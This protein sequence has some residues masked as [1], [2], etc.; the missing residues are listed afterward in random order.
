MVAIVLGAGSGE[1]VA[2]GEPKA[3]LEIGGRPLLAWAAEAMATAPEVGSLVVTA[4]DGAR[5]RAQACLEG[6]PVPVRVVTGGATRQASVKAAL[7]AVPA[8]AEVVVIHDAARPFA[9]PALCSRVVV[10]VRSGADGAVPVVAVSDTVK[11]VRDGR[12]ERTIDRATLALAQT[13]QAFRAELLRTAHERAA[14]SGVSV[15]DDAALLEEAADVRAVDGEAHNVK[16]T[17]P[18]D[19]DRARTMAAEVRGD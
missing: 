1:R 9:S 8:S 17:T 2:T 14:G 19:L 13:P 7:A 3:F 10:A 6:L 12:I 11:R 5:S 18:A 15:T 4:P 16:I